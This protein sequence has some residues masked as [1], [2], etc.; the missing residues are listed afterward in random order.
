[1]ICTK[2]QSDNIKV[3]ESRDADSGL[4]IRRRRECENCKNRF[5]TFERI[6]LTNLLVIKKDNTRESYN[7]QKLE[8][9][10]W[11]ACGKRPITKQQIDYL[12][13]DLEQKWHSEGQEISTQSI[14][15]NVMEKLKKIDDIAYIRFASVYRDFKD[16]ET[17]NNELVEF[18]KRKE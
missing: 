7:R 10:I 1:V 16:I 12:I 6:E 8:Q 5:T 4:A 2:C 17:F 13:S 14:G 3:L 15:H 9:G 11:I 18:L